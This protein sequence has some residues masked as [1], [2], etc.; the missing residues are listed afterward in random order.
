MKKEQFIPAAGPYHMPETPA[1]VLDIQ[2]STRYYRTSLLTEVRLITVLPDNTAPSETVWTLEKESDDFDILMELAEALRNIRLIITF[3]GTGFDI[4]HLTKKYAAYRLPNP[5]EGKHFLDLLK[6]LRQFDALFPL[7]SHRLADY[8]RL[9][10]ENEVQAASS[11]AEKELLLTSLLPLEGFLA[12]NFTLASARTEGEAAIFELLPADPLPFS[13]R[14]ED[15]PFALT[16]EG[17]MACLSA[18][19]Y[20]E[21]LRRYYT[22]VSDYEFLTAEGYAV[23]RSVSALVGKDRK[24][25]AVRENCFSFFRCTESFLS[26]EAAVRRYVVSVFAY[27]RSGG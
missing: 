13:L 11:D 26:D 23:H 7:S 1:A 15:G 18:C 10:P 8:M 12:G 27:M 21:R 3:N 19:L 20:G 6:K 16:L 22:N 24:E 4:P 2:T 9:F 14:A 17:G 5:F 25:K